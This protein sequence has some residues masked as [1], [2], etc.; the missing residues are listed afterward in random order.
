M[1]PGSKVQ[2]VVPACR[3]RHLNLEPAKHE[4]VAIYI[5]N[6]RIPNV[7]GDFGSAKHGKIDVRLI[8]R[9]THFIEAGRKICLEKRKM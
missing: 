1:M 7:F 9:A 2:N 8:C 3:I 6:Q 4:E 5:V